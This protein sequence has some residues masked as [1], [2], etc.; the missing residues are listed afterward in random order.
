MIA[1]ERRSS[2]RWIQKKRNQIRESHRPLETFTFS[3]SEIRDTG[4]FWARGYMVELKESQKSVCVCY[5]VYIKQSIMTKIMPISLLFLKVRNYFHYALGKMAIFHITHILSSLFTNTSF[6]WQSQ[7][8][9]D[10]QDVSYIL[11]L[12]FCLKQ[13]L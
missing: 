10:R 3:L 13:F 12:I 6:H 2:R 4:C 5:F 8:Y 1:N 9:T 7:L 11:N